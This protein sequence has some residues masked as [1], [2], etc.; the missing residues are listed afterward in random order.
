[1]ECDEIPLMPYDDFSRWMHSKIYSKRV[2]CSGSFEITMRC[3]LRCVHCY[4]AEDQ[5]DHELKT[6]EVKGILDEIA[7]NGC[8]WLLITGG[9]PLIR[10]DFLELYTYAKKS[11]FLIT[12]FTNGTLI[13]PEVADHFATWRPF[14]VEITL[15][16][17]T[18]KTYEKITGI[19]GSYEKCLR[20]INLLVERKIPLRLKTMA[21]TLNKHELPA[22]KDLANQ[23]GLDFRFDPVLNPKLDGL[24]DPYRYRLS[25]KEAVDL[26]LQDKGRA[27]A[28]RIFWKTLQK[29]KRA[30]DL[31]ICGA[32]QN[33]FHI[34]AYG[35]LSLCLIARIPDYDLRK[36]SFH[37]VWYDLIPKVR[38][39]KRSLSD[40]CRRCGK[41][42]VCGQCP[43]WSVLEHGDQETL[44]EYLC[45]LTQRR[46]AVFAS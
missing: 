12:L 24:K 14:A 20:G 44:V 5:T 25:A 35:K 38:S 2:P 23:L 32:G 6:D 28:W 4:V 15:L 22:M 7:A 10:S 27:N 18:K 46:A 33:R 41:I 16:G 39:Q 37:E 34:D 8:L 11:G 36:G 42:A 21:I 31:Y 26:D 30:D 3:N 13:T 43:G 1:M 9:E 17:A 19:P 29:P 45:E 40:R